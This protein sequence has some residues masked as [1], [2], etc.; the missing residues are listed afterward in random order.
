MT[1]R[2]LAN[3]ASQRSRQNKMNGSMIKDKDSNILVDEQAIQ[4]RWKEYFKELLD[5]ENAREQMEETAPVEGLEREIMCKAIE[6]AMKQMKSK[7]A[8][9]PSGIS[10]DMLKTL[11]QDGI[12]WLHAI[13]NRF[14]KDKKLPRELKQSEIVTLYKQ[15]GDALEYGNDRGLKLLEAALKIHERVVDRRIRECVV[16][17]DNQFGFMTGRGTV[18]AVFIQSKCRRKYWRATT[19]GNGPSLTWKKLL[20]EYQKM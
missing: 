14:W 9:G 3:L 17:H 20:T 7:K 5:V 10:A 1:T 12:E 16:I 8:P 4:D 19:S 6:M 15:K 18:D 13:L 2:F 11:G